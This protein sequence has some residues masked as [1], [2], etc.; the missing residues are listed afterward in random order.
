MWKLVEKPLVLVIVGPTGVGKTE[1]SLRLAERLD[2]EIV[3]M[4][5]RLVYRGM[6]IGTAKP[7]RQEMQRVRHHM[8]DLA[9]PDEVWSLALFRK[10]ALQAIEDIQS[11]GK[12]PILVGGTG[13]Y[14]RALME[15]WV[16]PS[17]EPDPALRHCLEEWGREIG[18]KGLH[19]RLTILDGEA[20]RQI[21]ASNQRRIVRA[22]EVIFKT[23]RKFSAQQVKAAPDLQFYTIGLSR[24]RDELYRRV[25]ERIDQ[26][27]ERGLLDEVRQL[28]AK[29]YSEKNPP[30]SAI[31]YLE[32][33]E[34][35]EGGMSVE[36]AKV[37]MKRKTREFIR[38]QANWFKSGDTAI[39]WYAMEPD[40]LE[41]I[42]NDLRIANIINP[43]KT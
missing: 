17:Q 42:L 38:R 33:I 37:A 8:I 39:H 2:A 41:G 7:G 32:A 43:D 12:V 9:N 29:G 26:M 1:L 19:D 36:G 27:F 21:D 15:G 24:P 20:A 18:S 40:P 34:V 22:L 14:I 10:H 11:R 6:D 31:G 4:D 35:L 13:Q 5:S 28:L 30:F 23:G 16:I 3:S 25:D